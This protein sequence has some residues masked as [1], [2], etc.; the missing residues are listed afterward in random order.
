MH[1]TAGRLR[2]VTGAVN[3]A[4]VAEIRAQIDSDGLVA[5]T[6]LVANGT[7]GQP[8]DRRTK[9]ISLSRVSGLAGARPGTRRLHSGH[10][11]ATALAAMT[12]RSRSS[13]PGRTRAD[14]PARRCDD[15]QQVIP[16]ADA[17]CLK[18]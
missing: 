6:S 15:L 14:G 9:R 11:S 16:R 1:F 17:Q 7:V 4:R 2:D 13:P 18:S 3:D 8:V 5:I 12:G 10:C